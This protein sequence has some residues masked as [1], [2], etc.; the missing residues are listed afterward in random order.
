MNHVA[1]VVLE[2]IPEYEYIG[3]DINLLLVLVDPST[4]VAGAGDT[5]IQKAMRHFPASPAMLVAVTDNGFKAYA[6]FQ[7]HKL[8]AL[9]QMLQITWTAIDLDAAPAADNEL[10]F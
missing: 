6:H 7:T 5:V 2:A 8:L 3:A 10:P 1:E 9:V 4:A